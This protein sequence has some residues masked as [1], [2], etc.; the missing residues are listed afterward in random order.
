MKSPSSNVTSLI[1][2]ATSSN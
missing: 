1:A 2:N